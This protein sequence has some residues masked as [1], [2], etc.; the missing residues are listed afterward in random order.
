L[1]RTLGARVV[2]VEH[3]GQIVQAATINDYECSIATKYNR[4]E[5]KTEDIIPT[6]EHVQFTKH[7]NI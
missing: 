6:S 5:R 7:I 2:T 4:F 3:H 1:G